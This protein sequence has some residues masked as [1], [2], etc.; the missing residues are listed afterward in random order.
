MARAAALLPNP[1]LRVAGEGPAA[2]LLEGVAGVTRLGNLA[3]GAVRREMRGALAL[4]LPSIWYENFPRTIVEAFACGLPVIASRIGAL[5]DL[6]GEGKT[7]LLCEP[8]NPGDWAGKMAWA[9]EH[10]ERM[11]EMGRRARLEYET[12]FSAEVNYGLLM[13]IYA[14]VLAERKGEVSACMAG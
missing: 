3:G 5:A 2:H 9:L 7:G 10:P 6:V 4:V 11:M 8:G 1:N 14:S 13:D 12:Y